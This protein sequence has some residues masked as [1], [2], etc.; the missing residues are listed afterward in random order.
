MHISEVE[1]HRM[2]KEHKMRHGYQD[3]DNKRYPHVDEGAKHQGVYQYV[4]NKHA[5]ESKPEDY[6]NMMESIR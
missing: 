1:K 3:H 5:R 4:D 6:Q 2:E